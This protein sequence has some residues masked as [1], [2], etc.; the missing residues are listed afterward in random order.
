MSRHPLFKPY[1][2]LVAVCFFW[3]T[4]YLGIRMALESFPPM[5]LVC[6]RYLL[7]G[8]ITLAFT[9]ARG[10]YLPRGKELAWAC[11]SGMLVLGIGNGALVFAE[12]WISSGLAALVISL[13]PFWLLGINATL[14]PR[15]HV[16][17]AT[18]LGLIAGLAGAAL[19]V[20]PGAF[21]GGIHG[22][23]LK[24]FLALQFGMLGW[25]AG[26]LLQRRMPA[27]AHPIVGGAVQQLAAGLA[28]A[29][30]ALAS[31]GQIHWSMR[32]SGALLYLVIFGS[33]VGYSAYVLAMARLPVAVVSLY[34]YINPVVAV[35]LGWLLFRE[36]FGLRET[37]AMLIIFLGVAIVKNFER[38]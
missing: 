9:R 27:R 37:I 24:G 33:I 5:L 23:M 21:E 32:G 30:L 15:E 11:F 19:L 7:S 29:P 26:S 3:G 2:A 10:L 20:G 13:S 14:P 17:P 31:G 6:A 1:L 36:P 25:N 28:C 16:R 12:L 35:L 22:G 18:W 8:S 34:N 38:H 4:T